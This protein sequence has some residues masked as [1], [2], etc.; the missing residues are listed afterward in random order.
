MSKRIKGCWKVD[1][2]WAFAVVLVMGLLPTT[3]SAQPAEAAPILDG[4]VDAK[5]LSGV[6]YH[7]LAA[8]YDDESSTLY[9]AAADGERFDPVM[10]QIYKVP[11]ADINHVNVVSNADAEDAKGD[12]QKRGCTVRLVAKEADFGFVG[13]EEG[14]VSD[15]RFT[16]DWAELQVEPTKEALFGFFECEHA[17]HMQAELEKLRKEVHKGM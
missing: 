3:A 12:N 5:N 6:N 13:L 11:V 17:R 7:F 9:W 1:V 15:G 16:V 10:E 14:Q 4:M 8:G 2:R